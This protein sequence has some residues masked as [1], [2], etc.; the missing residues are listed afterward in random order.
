M[1]TLVFFA[2]YNEAGNVAS[3][4]DRIMAV[5]SNA[6]ILVVD[7]S[8]KDGTLDVLASVARSSLKVIV[9]PGKLGWVRHICWRGS[10]LSIMATTC[11]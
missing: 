9:R 2:T 11:W 1:K 7:D 8:S 5:A 6:D 3:M 10:M 4:I